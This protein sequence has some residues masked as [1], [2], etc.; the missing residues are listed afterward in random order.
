LC[1]K[2]DRPPPNF[3]SRFCL[4]KLV[5]PNGLVFFGN[6]VPDPVTSM[7]LQDTLPSNSDHCIRNCCHMVRFVGVRLGAALGDD[8]RRFRGGSDWLGTS[9]GG[10]AGPG[11][12]RATPSQS[13]PP[14]KRRKSSPR[15]GPRR[16]PTKRTIGPYYMIRNIPAGEET[17]FSTLSV[18]CRF[19]G[20]P[21]TPTLPSLL[22]EAESKTRIQSSPK[23]CSRPKRTRMGVGSKCLDITRAP[24][25]S[26]SAKRSIRADALPC[27]K[28][29]MAC[30]T[31]AKYSVL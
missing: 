2:F 18:P 8:F 22:P 28:I 7:R 31:A 29:S 1:H 30:A 27:C 13:E 14:R 19:S 24:A 15:A 17:W 9:P 25:L 6:F 10:R 26:S 12:F 23:T 20:P 3:Y 5:Q 11:T 21:P 4:P 16:T